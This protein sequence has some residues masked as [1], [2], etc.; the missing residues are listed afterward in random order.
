MSRALIWALSHLLFVQSYFLVKNLL[1]SFPKEDSTK[2]DWY[3][4]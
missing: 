3:K 1:E 4:C 2:P